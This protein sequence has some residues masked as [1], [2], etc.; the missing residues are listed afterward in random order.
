MLQGGQ[1]VLAHAEKLYC[2]PVTRGNFVTKGNFVASVYWDVPHVG[3][4]YG[5]QCGRRR[6]QDT[7]GPRARGSSIV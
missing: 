2:C 7:W 3:D 4:K 5:R 1:C 6:T